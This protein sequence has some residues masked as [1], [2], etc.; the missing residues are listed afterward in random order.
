MEAGVKKF[1]PSVELS[2]VEGCF[3][4]ELCNSPADSALSISRARIEP[5]ASPGW[6]RLP[7]ICERYVVVEGVGAVEVNGQAAAQIGPGD[8]VVIPP[9]E[10]QRITNSGSCDLI[11]LAL[12]TP[13]FVQGDYEDTEDA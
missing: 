6:R 13:R 3:I 10:R 1:D 11:Y 4:T 12:C 7:G 2:F 9:G 8:V 5:G